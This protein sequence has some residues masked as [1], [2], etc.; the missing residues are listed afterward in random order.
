MT[1][2]P[3]WDLPPGTDVLA[4]LTDL[5][6]RY[7]IAAGP[8]LAAD[9]HL[10]DV[11]DLVLTRTSALAYRERL[12]SLTHAGHW[13]AGDRSENT[14]GLPAGPTA[15]RPDRRPTRPVTGVGGPTAG[16]LADHP[17]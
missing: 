8:P 12:L 17:Q 13:W 7:E 11:F 1:V 16:G 2:L 14:S 5:Y 4:D 6:Q 3:S 10:L 9:P 15:P